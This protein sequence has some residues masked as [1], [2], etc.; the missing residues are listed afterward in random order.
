MIDRILLAP[1]W[2]TLKIRHLLY[3]K[4]WRK[5][6]RTEIPSI[7]LGNVT[8]GGTGK[9]PHTEMIVRMLQSEFNYSANEI[10]VL[11]R[12]YKRKSKGFQQVCA[13][14]NASFYGDEPL[15]IK[16][17]FTDV[18]VLV[19]KDRLHAAELAQNPEKASTDK[20]ARKCVNKDF[21]PA[22]ILI[23]DDALQYRKLNPDISIMLVDYERPVFN[24]HL[25]PIGTL[26]DLPERVKAADIVIVS[27]APSYI[28][29]EER[30]RWRKKLRLD[31][32]QLLF[33]TRIDYCKFEAIFPEGEPRFLYS[34]RVVL[35]SGIAND[36][37]LVKW[38]S[39]EHHIV[40]HLR[41]PDHHKFTAADINSINSASQ[42]CPTAVVVTTEKDGQRIKDY[43]KIPETLREKMFQVP[44]EV[45][46]VGEGERE[47][48][49]SAIAHRLQV[50]RSES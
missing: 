49:T 27:K 19:D 35:F 21:A 20:K 6:S 34:K 3:N 14:G 32:N 9:T 47:R 7:A 41:F 40:S 23:L 12:G 39:D 26:R 4:G 25:I 29:N 48:F 42:A 31:D 2:C 33:F 36:N 16:K 50:S 8:V 46:F 1:Y 43:A 45:I 11:S 28:D 13:D 30:L 5:S 24:D 37:P 38:L 18:T 10:A 17:K 44:I 15:Q 22:G